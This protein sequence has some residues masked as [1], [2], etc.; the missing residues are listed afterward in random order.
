MT[1]ATLQRYRDVENR[2]RWRLV[3]SD[4]HP[5]AD[6]TQSFETAGG[7]DGHLDALRDRLPPLAVIDGTDGAVLID[8]DTAIALSAEGTLTHRKAAISPP[9]GDT[10]TIDWQPADDGTASVPEATAVQAVDGGAFVIHHGHDGELRWRAIIDAEVVAESGEG[11]ADD[12][13]VGRAIDRT[14]AAIAD[15]TVSTW[16]T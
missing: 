7:L 3:A 11:Y 4:G 9:L 10:D 5:L 15:A 2:W 12:A 14:T 1:N 6:G 13:A 8:G 16:G